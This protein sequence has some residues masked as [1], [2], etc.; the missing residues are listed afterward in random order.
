MPDLPQRVPRPGDRAHVTHTPA[1]PLSD[2]RPSAHARGYGRR[3]QRLR[4]TIL[5]RDPI[6]VRCERRASIDIDHIVPKERGGTDAASNL[7]GLCHG[8]HSRKTCVADGGWGRP[9]KG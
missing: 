9:R 4:L 2:P 5:Y 6:C 7:Q 8:C 3:W 1:V